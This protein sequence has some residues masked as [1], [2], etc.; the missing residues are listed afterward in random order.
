MARATVV[1][2]GAGHVIVPVDG[3]GVSDWDA[4]TYEAVSHPQ[5]AWGRAVVESL[6]LRGDETALDAGC[7]TGRITRLLAE[8]LPRGR[9][10]ALDASAGMVREATRQLADHAPRVTVRR[11]DLL[12]LDLGSPVDLVFSTATFHWILDHD[13]LFARLYRALV[14]GGRLVAQCGGHGNLRHALAGVDAVNASAPFAAYLADAGRA[15]H[16]ADPATTRARLE[17]AGFTAA[18]AT[19]RDAPVDMGRPAEATAFLR[20]VV[21]RPFLPALPADLHTPYVEAVAE[22]L[23]DPTGRLPLDYV[24]LDLE[25]RRPGGWG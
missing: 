24:R 1:G 8:R 12:E 13:T 17:R 21:L 20:T 25:A 7:G 19:L 3:V 4:R 6:T 23:A 16:F 14:P 22:R 9:V 5:F 18:R 10:I 15:V 2:D 11:G